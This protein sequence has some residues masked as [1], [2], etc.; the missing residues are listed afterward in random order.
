[1]LFGAR[2]IIKLYICIIII[3]ASKQFNRHQCMQTIQSDRINIHD[4][5][6]SSAGCDA[7]L[8]YTLC[9]LTLNRAKQRAKNNGPTM[10]E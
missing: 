10:N 5:H 4:A 6:V 9:L 2:S 1:M 3:E 7:V 8:G